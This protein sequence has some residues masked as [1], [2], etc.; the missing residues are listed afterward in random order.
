M[1]ASLKLLYDEIARIDK[2]VKTK[3]KL[4]NLPI[5]ILSDK[6]IK[7]LT[8]T[9]IDFSE[10][11]DRLSVV[12]EE[13]KDSKV[14]SKLHEAKEMKIE[15]LFNELRAKEKTVNENISSLMVEFE[16]IK[17]EDE[18]MLRSTQQRAITTNHED[19]HDH[20]SRSE[21]SS[22][23]G[24][25]DKLNINKIFLN[26]IMTTN[27]V[28]ILQEK[29]TLE[30]EK[31][32]ITDIFKLK[33]LFPSSE[34]KELILLDYFMNI[35]SFCLRQKYTIEKIS[36]VMSIFYFIFSY[37]FINNNVPSDKSFN[38]YQDIISFH[39]LCRPPFSYQVFSKEDKETLI[40]Y[41][42][43][44]FFRNYTLFENIFRYEVSMCFFS[45]DFKPIPLKPF[46][47]N[48]M[49]LLKPE[50]VTVEVPEFVKKIMNEKQI[51]KE[52]K[53]EDRL[54]K[55]NEE[56]MKTKTQE[57]IEDEKQMEKLKAFINSFYKASNKFEQG[58]QTEDSK[59]QQK[60]MVEALEVKG[61]LE[62]K[63][64]ELEKEIDEKVELVTRNILNPVNEA[65]AEKTKG[66]K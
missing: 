36:T 23:S 65:L 26:T 35:Y 39:S 16:R 11:L 19:D 55:E 7:Q 41:G 6:E 10:R 46:S 47:K 5:N 66:K 30:E 53:E 17:R 20:E 40:Q 24:D 29:S 1:N 51:E 60:K 37:S 14:T 43:N 50:L 22:D 54:N 3:M 42:K 9:F 4:L 13:E 61:F 62:A 49:Y 38:L 18:E 48:D 59:Q 45:K 34:S 58:K 21:G 63:I 28:I 31:Q 12:F 32:Y 25:Q 2:I 44:S 57:E 27:H 64:P 15:V 56:L 33:E 52:E 8:K